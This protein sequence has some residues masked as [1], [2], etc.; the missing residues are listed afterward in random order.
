MKQPQENKQVETF[1]LF[2]KR[3]QVRG[4]GFQE[5]LK[6]LKPGARRNEV[7]LTLQSTPLVSPL[8]KQGLFNAASLFFFFPFISFNDLQLTFHFFSQ[9]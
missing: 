1:K 6:F 4:L 2:K 8:K 9:I 3:G 5:V 7:P